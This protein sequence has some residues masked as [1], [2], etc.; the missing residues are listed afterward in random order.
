[1]DER[2]KPTMSLEAMDPGKAAAP[3]DAAQPAVP[4]TASPAA[5]SAAT[6]TVAPP[7]PAA[8]AGPKAAT[9]P[10][11]TPPPDA[12]PAVMPFW[13]RMPRFFLFP[14]QH[15]PLVRNLAATGVMCAAGT[16]ALAQMSSAP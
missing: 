15:A 2:E 9:A 13:Q 10:P 8:A 6:S 1:M 12:P 7:A 14:L 4:P 3:S 5:A 16:L 11:D